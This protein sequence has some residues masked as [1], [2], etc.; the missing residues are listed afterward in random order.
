VRHAMTNGTLASVKALSATIEVAPGT[1][2]LFMR[3]GGLTRRVAVEVASALG[4]EG[5]AF[6]SEVAERVNPRRYVPHEARALELRDVDTLR[7]GNVRRVT[8]ADRTAHVFEP[9]SLRPSRFEVARLVEAFALLD[10]VPDGLTL[11]DVLRAEDAYRQ[12]R[13]IPR[14]VSTRHWVKT[15]GSIL[16]RSSEKDAMPDDEDGEDRGKSG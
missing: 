8:R 1:L 3:G 16:R 13:A 10:I 5:F 15:H 14:G 4:A 2:Y 7:A 6:D 9:L 12:A 11:E